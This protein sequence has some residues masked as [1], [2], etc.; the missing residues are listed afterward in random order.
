MPALSATFPTFLRGRPSRND[1]NRTQRKKTVAQSH[2]YKILPAMP[3]IAALLIIATL[4][5]FSAFGQ[6]RGKPAPTTRKPAPAPATKPAA[7]KPAPPPPP[8]DIRFKSRYTTGD[9]TTESATYI[10]GTRERYEM[11]DM[12]LLRQH[13]QK[14]TIQISRSANTY[15]IVPETESTTA[16]TGSGA[17]VLET[18]IADV[19]ERKE[20]FGQQA[21]R[22]VTVLD[23]QPQAGACDQT[24]QRIETDAWYIDA[25]KAVAAQPA[26]PSQ[27]SAAACRDELKVN[28][29]GDAALLGFPLSYTTTTPGADGKPI[30]MQM[31]VTEFE[32]T[33]LDPQLF[34]IPEGM[35]AATSGR[36][37]AR[38]VSDA[39]EKKLAANPASAVPGAKPAEAGKPRG[40]RIGVPELGNKTT[41]SADTRA[42]RTQLI[43][44]LAEQK[45][46]G[47]PLAAAP[48]DELNQHA[49]DLGLDYLLMAQITELKAS[50]PGRIGRLVK[51]TTGDTAEKDVTEAKLSVQLVPV[52]AAKPRLSTNTSG[53][54]GGMGLKTGLQLAKV[55]ASLYLRYASPLGALNSMQLMNMQGM[56]FLNNPT[57]MQLQTAGPF[58]TGRGLD[59]TA[60]AA[61]FLMDA[62][63]EGSG[64]PSDGP[65][66]DASLTEAIDEAA[67]KVRENL[68]R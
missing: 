32:I 44:E 36:E 24:K 53:N 33:N 25:P 37:L 9:Q 12:I 20:M 40:S 47:V 51:R 27:S 45:I 38:A 16:V 11:G 6:A 2:I 67:K 56:S 54:D 8:S 61:M 65:S 3:K 19:G 55:A 21:R 17:V 49:K 57:L 31:E 22:V 43:A 48:Q 14:R 62:M 26:A 63:A 59:R 68:N 1:K 29:T 64:G 15:F 13:D 39:N 52:G 46:E 10:R 66:F 5:P 30:V 4:V 50:K 58:G 60:G 42:L 28:Q 41:Q 35:T 23:R 7:T 18:S 34:E